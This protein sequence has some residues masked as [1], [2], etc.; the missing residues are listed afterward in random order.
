MAVTPERVVSA[1]RFMAKLEKVHK[2]T[3]W[4]LCTNAACDALGVLHCRGSFRV[5]LEKIYTVAACCA[6]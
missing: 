3:D 6:Q 4:L 2:V 1:K 5:M